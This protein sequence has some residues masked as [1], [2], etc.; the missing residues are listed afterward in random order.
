M[1]GNGGTAESLDA[2]KRWL[3]ARK[4]DYQ[5]LELDLDLIESRVL[6]SLTFLE[7]VF[8]LEEVTGREIKV[9]R[10]VVDSFR[11]LRSI[12][13]KIFHGHPRSQ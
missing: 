12:E 13:E 8:F 11:T 2:V 9:T 7:F 5:D 1:N 10:E 3:L 4:P 6:D